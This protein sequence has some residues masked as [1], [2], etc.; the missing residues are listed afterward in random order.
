MKIA[1]LGYG[2]MGKLIEKS[3]LERG[4]EIVSVID[5][6][7]KSDF[8]GAQACI[9]FSHPDAVL[10]NVEKAAKS[11]TNIVIGTTGWEEQSGDV[12]KLVSGA[13][14]GCV[15]S[16][17]F[18]LGVQLFLR[19]VKHAAALMDSYA[20]YD[21]SGIEMHHREK[22][23]SPSGTAKAIAKSLVEGLKR[24]E[25]AVYHPGERRIEENELH[26]SSLR[27]GQIPGTHS[28]IFDSLIDS[29][30]L[31]H[32]AKNRSGFALGAVAAAEMI[33]DKKGLFTF[34]ELL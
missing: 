12:E 13:G 28:V 10:D 31:T 14:I 33:G 32:E 17:N 29:I 19:I 8:N 20:Q 7:E 21:V 23:D 24:K 9:D 15:Y 11:Q 30:T 25:L 6:A 4:H 26:F 27:C 3:A 5:S 2:K 1:I 34:E 16:P 18:S 22:V